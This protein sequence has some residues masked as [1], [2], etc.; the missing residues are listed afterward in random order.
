MEYSEEEAEALLDLFGL[1]WFQW[2][3]EKYYYVIVDH[4]RYKHSFVGNT[5]REALNK[6]VKEYANNR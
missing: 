2:K 3:S 5:A 4:G 6:T 1:K